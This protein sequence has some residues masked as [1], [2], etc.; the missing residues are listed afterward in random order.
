M[1]NDVA[2]GAT[3][4]SITF[5][6]NIATATNPSGS[7]PQSALW[8]PMG[9]IKVTSTTFYWTFTIRQTGKSSTPNI[10]I[11]LSDLTKL[12]PGWGVKGLFYNGP[13]L[14]DGSGLLIGNVMWPNIRKYFSEN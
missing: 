11:G 7:V 10:A 6:G 9:Q 1:P 14:S 12:A 13:N 8:Y 4:K 3:A 2:M 5:N